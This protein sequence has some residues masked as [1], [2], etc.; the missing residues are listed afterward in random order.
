MSGKLLLVAGAEDQNLILSARN[1]RDVKLVTV[2]HLSVKDIVG[3]D[4]IVATEE[5]LRQIEEV[6]Q[7]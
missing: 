7:A 4:A 3:A 6:Y 1:L 2:N 5:A